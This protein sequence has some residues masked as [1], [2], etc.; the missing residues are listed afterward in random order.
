MEKETIIKNSFQYGR[1][2][3]QGQ[4]TSGDSLEDQDNK[5]KEFA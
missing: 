3:T 2:S 5:A 1:V 4:M